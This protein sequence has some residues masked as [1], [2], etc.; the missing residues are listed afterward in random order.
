MRQF[1]SK[2]DHDLLKTAEIFLS[3]KILWDLPF[4]NNKDLVTMYI[5]KSILL[6]GESKHD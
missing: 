3:I 4:T 6:Q 2:W 1:A 5:V